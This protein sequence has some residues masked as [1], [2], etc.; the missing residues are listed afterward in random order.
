MVTVGNQLL[1]AAIDG[2]SAIRIP[3]AAPL[4]LSAAASFDPDCAGL[5][6]AA[7]ASE[8]A[9]A[10][11][12]A[13]R[14]FDGAVTGPCRDSSGGALAL[15]PAARLAL[16]AGALPASDWPY[17]FTVTVSK[18]GRA[19]AAAAVPVEVVAGAALLVSVEAVCW[20]HPADSSPCCA[21]PDGTT[22][23]NGDSRLRFAA[24][25]DAPASFAWSVSPVLPADAA[26]AAAPIGY[27]GVQ[28]VLQAGPAFVPGNRYTVAVAAAAAAGGA[29]GSGA[30]ALVINSPPM[31]GSFSA[32]LLPA[33]GAAAGEGAACERAGQAVLDVFRLACAGWADPD[34]D[35]LLLFRFAYLPRPP[36][37]D[38]VAAAAADAAAAAEAG[39]GGGNGTGWLDWGPDAVRD[40]ALPGG[41]LLLLAQVRMP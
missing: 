41:E 5:S 19:P 35:P 37:P 15:P 10:F 3:A 30:K 21:A 32:C 27:E 31:G 17:V 22:L 38:P 34:G 16:P 12:W 4:S 9:L 24:S 29:T 13:C 28:F 36:L 40:M 33:G 14:V 25:A 11:A 26:A 18:P 39:G 8:A 20:Q 1:V 6:A 23:A 7:A 2:G